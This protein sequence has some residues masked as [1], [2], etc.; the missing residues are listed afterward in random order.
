MI[1]AGAAEVGG[2]WWIPVLVGV[3]GAV[4]T[5]LVALGGAAARERRRRREMYAGAV[6]VLIGWIEYP[7]QVRRRTSDDAEELGRLRDIG[8]ELQQD[9]AYQQALLTGDSKSLGDL[10][11][12]VVARVK[13]QTAPW[14][15]EAWRSAPVSDPAGMILG[16]WG[17]GAFHGE[18]ATLRTAIGARFGWRRFAAWLDG[19]AVELPSSDDTTTLAMAVKENG[20]TGSTPPCG[21]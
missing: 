14:L 18:L 15:A 11:G 20:R 3:A 19:D 4:V 17:A 2:G 6:R 21:E 13:A 1:A 8:H 12:A 5:L 9:L 16:D 7:Y 10:F